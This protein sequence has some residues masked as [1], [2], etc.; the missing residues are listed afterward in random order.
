MCYLSNLKFQKQRVFHRHSGVE[1]LNRSAIRISKFVVPFSI[2]VF[3]E[4][5]RDI[6]PSVAQFILKSLIN[7]ILG[8]RYSI[9]S[10]WLSNSLE[11]QERLLGAI[12]KK[13]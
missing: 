6:D 5:C 3:T 11:G 10:H 4:V 12:R 8:A 7:Q 9:T 1:I 2:N 13:P